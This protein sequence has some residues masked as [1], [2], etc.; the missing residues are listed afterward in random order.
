MKYFA[1]CLNDKGKVF[2]SGEFN[3]LF[4]IRIWAEQRHATTV[5]VYLNNCDGTLTQVQLWM[6]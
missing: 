3:R 6:K 4:E 5:N 2:A 1:E